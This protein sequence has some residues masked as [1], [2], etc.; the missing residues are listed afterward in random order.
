MNSL[1]LHAILAFVIVFVASTAICQQ[2]YSPGNDVRCARLWDELSFGGNSLDCDQNERK[3]NL[4]NFDCK[5]ESVIVRN[6]CTLTVYD[7]TG[8]KRTIEGS[9]TCLWGVS[10]IIA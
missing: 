1:N 6:G 7:K 5:A 8:C 2:F 9:S 3:S 4:G 10:A